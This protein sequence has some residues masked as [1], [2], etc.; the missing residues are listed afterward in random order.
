MVA[1]PDGSLRWP[2]VGFARYREVAPVLQYQIVQRSLENLEV[3]LVVERPLRAEEEAHLGE[4]IRDSLGFAFDL[5]FVYFD[6]AIPKGPGGKF[7]EF[8]RDMSAEQGGARVQ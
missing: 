8:V 3:R 4:I 6:Q 7:E 2:L 5:R 1:Y